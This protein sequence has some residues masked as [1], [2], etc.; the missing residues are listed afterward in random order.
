MNGRMTENEEFRMLWK[1]ADMAYFKV[2][3]QHL[4]AGTTEIHKKPQAG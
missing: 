4:P 3:S 1:E 2:L